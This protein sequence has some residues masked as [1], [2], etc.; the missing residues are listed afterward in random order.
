MCRS[1]RPFNEPLAGIRRRD[2]PVAAVGR[3][4]AQAHTR[5]ESHSSWLIDK[6]QVRTTLT[7]P[8]KEAENIARRPPAVR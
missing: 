1:P 8:D 4:P 2:Q 6:R 3:R 5:S 7:F